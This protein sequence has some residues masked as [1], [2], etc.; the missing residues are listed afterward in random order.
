[1]S[2]GLL[3]QNRQN[4]PLRN[5]LHSIFS[6]NAASAVKGKD[7][8]TFRSKSIVAVCVFIACF[9]HVHSSS[10]CDDECGFLND[11]II[12]ND[13]V[14]DCKD[15]KNDKDMY[16]NESANSLRVKENMHLFLLFG[17]PYKLA[18]AWK[19]TVF[20]SSNSGHLVVTSNACKYHKCGVLVVPSLRLQV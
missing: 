5:V 9:S 20:P 18:A 15:D 1:M 14:T 17:F 11:C 3:F 7:M 10:F 8:Q 16:V 2:L 12:E 13:I 19:I 6:S 4:F